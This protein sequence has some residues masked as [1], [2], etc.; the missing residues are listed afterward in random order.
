MNSAREEIEGASSPN[1]L[2]VSEE[3]GLLRRG[4]QLYVRP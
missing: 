1:R 4:N 3:D 2:W